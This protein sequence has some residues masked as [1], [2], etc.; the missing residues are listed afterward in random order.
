MV[1][2]AQ[3]VTLV[4]SS[5]KVTFNFFNLTGIKATITEGKTKTSVNVTTP[6]QVFVKKYSKGK[7]TLKV[8][9]GTVVKTVT[10]V[11]P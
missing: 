10:V 2:G 8:T 11:V 7:H 6:N 3:A 5:K 9:A 4:P 1:W